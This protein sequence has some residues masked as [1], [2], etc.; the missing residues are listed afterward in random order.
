MCRSIHTLYHLD[1]PA[2]QAEIH[3]ASLQYVRKISGFNKPSKINETAFNAAVDD[4]EAIST[5]LLAD[6]QTH[7]LKRD[8]MQGEIQ[9]RE[10][11]LPQVETV[12]Q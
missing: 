8:R 9:Y 2:T 1:P 12:D 10:G 6:L 11:S 3:A 5:R 7:A 4:V